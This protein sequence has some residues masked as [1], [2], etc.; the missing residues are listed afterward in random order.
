MTTGHRM[1]VYLPRDRGYVV[2]AEI[3]EKATSKEVS[4]LLTLIESGLLSGLAAKTEL[5][6]LLDELYDGFSN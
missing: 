2:Q 4:G 6:E 3:W 5:R 1:E